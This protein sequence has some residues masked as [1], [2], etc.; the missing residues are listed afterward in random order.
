M[1]FYFILEEKPIVKASLCTDRNDLKFREDTIRGDELIDRQIKG[2]LVEI[3][4]G[5]GDLERMKATVAKL[6]Q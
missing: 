1:I 6:Y 3:L 5:K 4:D 2:L